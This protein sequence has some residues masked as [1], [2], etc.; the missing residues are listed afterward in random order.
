MSHLEEKLAFRIKLE[1]LP[2]PVRE[3]KFHPRRKWKADF[4]WPEAR[5]FPSNELAP[6]MLEVEGGTW[7][8][9]RH[10]RGDGYANDCE[11]YNAAVTL[12]WRV[13]RVTSE[14]VNDG[15][16]IRVLKAI[17]DSKATY[18]LIRAMEMEQ[19]AA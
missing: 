6:I 3:Y 10:V 9:G 14:M 13:L 7:G 16:A 12:G 8:G 11:K 18:D 1:G 4:A 19:S 17:L 5:L 15:R 2:D